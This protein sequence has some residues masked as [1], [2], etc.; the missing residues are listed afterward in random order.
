MNGLDTP[1]DGEDCLLPNCYRCFCHRQLAEWLNP[2]A[3]FK[4][5]LPAEM[6][7]AVKKRFPNPPGLNYRGFIWQDG[8]A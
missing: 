1:L 4:E 5:E 3:N 6:E 7:A 2:H 8:F